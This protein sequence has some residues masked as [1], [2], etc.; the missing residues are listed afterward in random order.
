M[1]S[2]AISLVY[3]YQP[4][5]LLAIIS[6]IIMITNALTLMMKMLTEAMT[7]GTVKV[8]ASCGIWV[9]G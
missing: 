5:F 8:V 7:R 1:R 3:A 4:D 2:I 9:T 6:V